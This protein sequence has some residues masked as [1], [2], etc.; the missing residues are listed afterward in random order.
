MLIGFT[1][2]IQFFLHQILCHL[3]KIIK[4]IYNEMSCVYTCTVY[5]HEN[6]LNSV[7]GRFPFLDSCSKSLCMLAYCTWHC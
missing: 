6:L 3:E 1:V 4:E 7:A 2:D 5:H